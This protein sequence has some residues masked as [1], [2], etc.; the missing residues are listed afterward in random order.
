[1]AVRTALRGASPFAEVTDMSSDRKQVSA[2]TWNEPQP[3]VV[4]LGTAVF[5][6]DCEAISNSRGTECHACGSHSL[7]SLARILGGCLRE[8]R[9]RSFE[10]RSNYK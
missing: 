5:C 10:S 1:M 4:P 8:H 2:A 6:L 9:C 3:D 7:V